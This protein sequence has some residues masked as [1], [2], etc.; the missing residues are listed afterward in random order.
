MDRMGQLRISRVLVPCLVLAAVGFCGLAAQTLLGSRD[1]QA[2]RSVELFSWG[3]WNRQQQALIRRT[4]ALTSSLSHLKGSGVSGLEDQGRAIK[5][6][7]RSLTRMVRPQRAAAAAR[8]AAAGQKHYRTMDQELAI[9]KVQKQMRS[10]AHFPKDHIH[11]A[12]DVV[13]Q[14]GEQDERDLNNA[15]F[16]PNPS[17]PNTHTADLFEN[18]EDGSLTVEDAELCGRRASAIKQLTQDAINRQIAESPPQDPSEAPAASKENSARSQLIADAMIG[19]E[20]LERLRQEK[21]RIASL[22]GELHRKVRKAGVH[23]SGLRAAGGHARRQQLVVDDE[24]GNKWDVEPPHNNQRKCSCEEPGAVLEEDEEEEGADSAA[25]Q[26]I[27]SAWTAGAENGMVRTGPPDGAARA[28]PKPAKCLCFGPRETATQGSPYG[29]PLD[30]GAPGAWPAGLEGRQDRV[31]GSGAPAFAIA[32]RPRHARFHVIPHAMARMRA[33]REDREDPRTEHLVGAAARMERRERLAR[34]EGAA[35]RSKGALGVPAA[36]AG[37][38]HTAR[39]SPAE[40]AKGVPAAHKS[41]AHGGAEKAKRVAAPA[42]REKPPG[43][44]AETS[45][46]KA[47]SPHAAEARKAPVAHAAGASEPPA[48]HATEAS[49]GAAVG[50]LA[51]LRDLA[52]AAKSAGSEPAHKGGAGSGQLER[53][54]KAITDAQA[55]LAAKK[56]AFTRE[57]ARRQT[58]LQDEFLQSMEDVHTGL[59]LV[60]GGKGPAQDAAA[61]VGP[62]TGSTQ[63]KILAAQQN[64]LQAVQDQEMAAQE[65]VPPAGASQQK[66][67]PLVQAVMAKVRQ[68]ALFQHPPQTAASAPARPHDKASERAALQAA[69]DQ[70]FAQIASDGPAPAAPKPGRYSRV[71]R[72]VGDAVRGDAGADAGGAGPAAAPPAAA[73]QPARKAKTVQGLRQLA[74]PAGPAPAAGAARGEAKGLATLGELSSQANRDIRRAFRGRPLLHEAAAAAVEADERRGDPAAT[75]ADSEKVLCTVARLKSGLCSQGVAPPP[76]PPPALVDGQ[77]A[78]GERGE[79]VP[80]RPLASEPGVLAAVGRAQWGAEARGQGRRR[81]SIATLAGDM[82]HNIAGMFSQ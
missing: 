20:Y 69:L 80:A 13:G 64:F 50:N 24:G 49:K 67:D 81:A 19:K 33:A 48:L 11:G 4:N 76:P 6:G 53:L 41:P 7:L 10:E 61:V 54:E 58:Q 75:L 37:A 8:R 5:D 51:A 82:A 3:A 1:E 57:L 30:H 35:K 39:Q 14:L 70:Q 21:K 52:T 34:R 36:S 62:A 65:L 15:L 55:K 66:Q 73:A 2:W 25:R 78:T 29:G 40:V 63:A 42:A 31:D 16:L 68:S 22:T 60:A 28:Q 18:C 23:I 59:A 47:S 56:L 45:A 77:P 43:A 72:A 74:G 12:G 46:R 17:G 26:D 71:A 9:L 27:R 44:Q 79:S 32:T 38:A